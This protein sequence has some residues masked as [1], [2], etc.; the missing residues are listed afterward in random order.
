[1]STAVGIEAQ[2]LAQYA[3]YA[4]GCTQ[5]CKYCC[6][7]VNSTLERSTQNIANKEMFSIHGHKAPVHTHIRTHFL[8]CACYLLLDACMSQTYLLKHFYTPVYL[9]LHTPLAG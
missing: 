9:H 4:C 2:Y 5:V 8:C 6:E 1:M 3:Q 7:K